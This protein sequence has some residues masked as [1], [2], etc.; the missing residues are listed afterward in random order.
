MRSGVVCYD[1]TFA[2]LLRES[3]SDFDSRL[4]IARVAGMG[5]FRTGVCAGL[6]MAL[7]LLG[8][9]SDDCVNGTGPIVSESID[10]STFDGFDFQAAGEVVAVPGTTQQVIVRA[11][12]NIIDVLNRD[13]LNGVWNIGFTECVGQ[14]SELRIEI[15]VPELRSV[16]LSGAGTIQAETVASATETVLSGAGTVTLSG[17]STSQAIAL[18]GSGTVEAFDLVT[19]ETTVLL[20]GQG[21]VNVTVNEQLNVDLPG[22]GSV[23]YQGDPQLNIR[24]T[25]AGSVVDANSVQN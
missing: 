5:I 6:G 11:E 23:L 8:C 3:C 2:G 10:L 24:I 1:A 19:D 25:G 13:V 12:Q 18:E 9:N 7:C 17:R 16:A 21:S 22:S 20:A 4:L 14:V 15:S